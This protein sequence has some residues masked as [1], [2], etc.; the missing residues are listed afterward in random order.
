MAFTRNKD[1]D[2]KILVDIENE[3]DFLALCSTEKYVRDLCNSDIV[4]RERLR[5]HYPDIFKNKPELEDWKLWYLQ[6]IKAIGEL[7]E[8]H[9]FVYKTG[10]P[11]IYLSLLN[12]YDKKVNTAIILGDNIYG[13]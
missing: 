1:I 3:R 9:N 12:R 6:N 5:K 4:Y 2:R 13:K 7:K 11:T 8:K 10:I